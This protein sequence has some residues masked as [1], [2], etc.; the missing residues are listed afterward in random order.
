MNTPFIETGLAGKMGASS[1]TFTSTLQFQRV[2]TP[3]TPF[4]D[5]PSGGWKPQ[6]DP[7]KPT[8]TPDYDGWGWDSW[9]TAKD[10]LQ[11]HKALKAKYGQEEAN[12]RFI[13]AWEKQSAGASPLDARSFDTEFR[14]Y[15]KA[16]GF[17]DGLYFGLGVM[18]KPI[19]MTTDVVTG[20]SRGLSAAA[21]ISQYLIP[22]LLAGFALFYFN[23]KAPRRK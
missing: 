23:A 1:R 13:M 18:V 9:W 3:L 8:S 2:T 19:G 16:N 6:N 7:T 12:Y 5:A 21:N 4:G 20:V 11:W 14:E 10:W 15:A 17:L 22:V